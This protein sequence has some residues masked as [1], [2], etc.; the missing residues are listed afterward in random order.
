MASTTNKA[1]I[2]QLTIITIN[3][4]GA[5]KKADL[6]ISLINTFNTDYI[7]LQET[8]F[9]SKYK[10]DTFIRSLGLET[11]EGNIDN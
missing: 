3:I 1:N 9:K 8:N 2:G 10:A 11:T 5:K 4:K 6:I 7:L